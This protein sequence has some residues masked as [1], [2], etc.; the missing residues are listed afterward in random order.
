MERNTKEY[1]LKIRGKDKVLCIIQMERNTLEIG[2][3]I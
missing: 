2:K 3:M 1:F